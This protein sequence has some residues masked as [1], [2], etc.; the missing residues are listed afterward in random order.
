MQEYDEARYNEALWVSGLLPD[1]E[2]LP[3]GDLTEIG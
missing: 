2:A 1:L 3:Q